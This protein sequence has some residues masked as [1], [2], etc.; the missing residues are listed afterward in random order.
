MLNIRAYL[1]DLLPENVFKGASLVLFTRITLLLSNLLIGI[2]LARNLGPSD[3]GVYSLIISLVTISVMFACL[4]LPTIALKESA[5]L[6]VKEKWS[7]LKGMLRFSLLF[8]LICSI[9]VIIVGYWVKDIFPSLLSDEASV[10]FYFGL[11]LVPV[12]SL[13]NVMSNTL[14]GLHIIAP[15][16]LV[17][18]TKQIVFLLLILAIFFYIS[19]VSVDQVVLSNV[20]ASLLSMILVVVFLF[21]NYPKELIV[22]KPIYEIKYWVFSAVPLFFIAGIQIINNRADIL[23]LGAMLSSYEVGIYDVAMRGA[24]LLVFFVI[25]FN[26]SIASTFSKL[27][28]EGDFERL[29]KITTSATRVIFMLTMPVA[30]V[31]FF[32]GD[33]LIV[34][35]FG[36]EYLAG[37]F[38]LNI[39][40]IGHLFNVITGPSDLLLT[41]SG[42]QKVTAI[43]MAF[44]AIVNVT[45]NYMLIP[46]YGV[47]GACVANLVSTV[48]WNSLLA[49]FCRKTLGIDT[50]ILGFKHDPSKLKSV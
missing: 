32:F 33:Y 13:I 46:L 36:E 40:M 9:F 35:V 2:L 6:L 48:L 11:M 22:V 42:Y 21:K 38:A 10:A 30:L 41:M 27:H 8:V 34:F 43:C 25:V 19:N 50:T 45:L 26:I 16:Q 12:L 28:T 47:E 15:S 49:I 7:L 29:S 5:R 39:L 24:E 18:I 14:R 31:L 20:V 37:L 3:Y 4:G 17:I 1:L 23:M 44:A